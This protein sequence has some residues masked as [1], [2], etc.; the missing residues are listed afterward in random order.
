MS[1]PTL[2]FLLGVELA[3]QCRICPP[4]Q[5]SLAVV[6]RGLLPYTARPFLPLPLPPAHLSLSMVWYATLPL[7][8]YLGPGLP[9]LPTIPYLDIRV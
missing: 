5:A 2:G 1:S 9:G 8:A 4:T 6:D 3:V 7:V